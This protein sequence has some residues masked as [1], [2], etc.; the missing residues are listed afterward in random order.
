MLTQNL[1][2]MGHK[3]GNFFKHFIPFRKA[4][5]VSCIVISEMNDKYAP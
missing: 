3:T 4:A 5:I 1:L 2:D